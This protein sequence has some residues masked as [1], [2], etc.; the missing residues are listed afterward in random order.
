MFFMLTLAKTWRY[1]SAPCGGAFIVVIEWV[2]ALDAAGVDGAGR[3]SR[4]TRVLH[5]LNAGLHIRSKGQRLF[6]QG[7][8]I[9]YSL[10]SSGR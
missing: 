10:P 5:R 6:L 8:L 1:I 7:I 9:S 2:L 4:D 3:G